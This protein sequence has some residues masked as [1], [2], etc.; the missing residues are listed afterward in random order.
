MEDFGHPQFT[1][2]QLARYLLNHPSKERQ[3]SALAFINLVTEFRYAMSVLSQRPALIDT[4]QYSP[5]Y[6]RRTYADMEREIARDLTQLPNFHA[7]IRL[8]G[9]EGFIR[10]QPL[11]QECNQRALQRRIDRIKARM[12]AS[13]VGYCRDF[14]DV[15]NEI[16]LRHQQ[17]Q[18]GDKETLVPRREPPNPPSRSGPARPGAPPP[19]WG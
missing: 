12:R 5:R 8:L 9:G 14:R 19:T 10:T 1:S 15:E 16:N 2:S 18:R 13:Q 6:E 11:P 7:K 17:W 3:R 4:G